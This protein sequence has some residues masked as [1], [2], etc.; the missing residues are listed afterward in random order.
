MT[1]WYGFHSI[2]F[3]SNASGE[4]PKYSNFNWDVIYFYTI[5]IVLNKNDGIAIILA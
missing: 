1:S 2:F 3:F 4:R 5:V